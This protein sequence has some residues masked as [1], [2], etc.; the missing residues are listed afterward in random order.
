MR[1]GAR[2]AALAVMVGLAVS[3]GHAA[4][5][6]AQSQPINLVVDVTRTGLIDLYVRGSPGAEVALAE[7]VEGELRYLRTVVLNSSGVV[8]VPAVASWRCDRQDR[9]FVASTT[10][11]DGRTATA[12]FDARTPSCRR[13]LS[14]SVPGSAR[15]RRRVRVKVRDKW[16]I[17]GIRA[18]LCSARRGGRSR[19]R[20]LRIPVGAKLVTGTVRLSARGVW[21]VELRTPYQRLRRSVYVG[22][23]RPARRRRRPRL[24]VTGDS[25]M[26]SL[27]SVLEDRLSGRTRFHRDLRV[28]T[29]I[30]KP[31]FDWRTRARRR[32]SMLRPRA[33]VV[34]IGANDGFAMEPPSGARVDCCGQAWIEEYARRARGM[35][36]AYARKGEGSVLW[37]TLP[38]PR[39]ERR[40]PLWAAVNEAFRRA[41][42][43]VPGVRLLEVDKVF[44]PGFRYRAV[45]RYR[46][47]RVRVRANDG[48]HLSVA[49]A[50]IAA[51]IIVSALRDEHVL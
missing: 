30:S 15:P 13:R 6:S 4:T 40:R 1:R 28:G 39:N 9:R 35:M 20:V 50:R 12:V 5:G 25:L 51:R 10:L 29:G 49:G 17:G 11:P 26:Q 2:T 16:K 27:D 23:K 44:T 3:A 46:G 24:L 47:R 42:P 33:T 8:G 22:V 48:L 18:R 14:F 34:F 32:A 31:G 45:M 36:R 19:C 41:A 43:A 7:S 21:R 37:L 38:A